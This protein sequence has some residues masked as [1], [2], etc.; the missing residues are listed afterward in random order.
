MSEPRAAR[1]RMLIITKKEYKD[2][3]VKWLKLAASEQQI[4]VTGDEGKI[5]IVLGSG[6]REGAGDED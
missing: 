1:G 6:P 3:P 2:Q 4:G 5:L